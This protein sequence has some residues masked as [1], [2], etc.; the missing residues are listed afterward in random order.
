MG[1]SDPLCKKSKVR[2]YR[3]S[4]KKIMTM[5]TSARTTYP[6]MFLACN[7]VSD[8]EEKSTSAANLG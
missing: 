5:S 8:V 6:T 1:L 3:W 4:K 2:Q 7:E